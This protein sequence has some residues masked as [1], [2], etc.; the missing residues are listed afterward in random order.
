MFAHTHTQNK[1]NVYTRTQ[2]QLWWAQSDA[3]CWLDVYNLWV[4]HHKLAFKRVKMLRCGILMS[5]LQFQFSKGFS[6]VWLCVDRNSLGRSS[7]RK[8]DCWTT[9]RTAAGAPRLPLGV[10]PTLAW[11]HASQ[12]LQPHLPHWQH[13]STRLHGFGCRPLQQSTSFHSSW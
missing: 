13:H 7:L 3:G 10:C 5:A 12:T 6:F 4:Q 1:I 2:W 11:L 8:A 9:A